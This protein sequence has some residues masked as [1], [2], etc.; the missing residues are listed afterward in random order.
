MGKTADDLAERCGPI[1]LLL[2][3]VDG[4]LTD[5]TIIVD[6]RGIETKNFYV[7]DGS[8][9]AMWR[10]A[11]KKA[12]IL[13]GRWARAVEHRAS[14][15]GIPWVLQGNLDKIQSFRKL[16]AA[17]KLEPR[18]VCYVGDDLLDLPVLRA[19]GLAAC[20][21]DAVAEVRAVAQLVTEAPGGRGAVREVVETVLRNQG[22][23]NDLVGRYDAPS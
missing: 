15:L 5:G 12:A 6:D 10:R 17:L 9:L 2:C 18:Q 14:E 7:R 3:D 1:E 19:A 20:P 16:L 13:S 23:W 8:A 11:G 22:G 4:V 21:A